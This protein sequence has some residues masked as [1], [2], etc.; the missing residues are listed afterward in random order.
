MKERVLARLPPRWRVLWERYGTIAIGTYFTV[1]FSCIGILFVLFDTGVL[2]PSDLPTHGVGVGDGPDA[3]DG[4]AS[5]YL[6]LLNRLGLESW[7]P[8]T[9]TPRMGNFAIAWLTTKLIEPL[10][11][12]ITIGLT[13]TVARAMGRVPKLDSGETD[14]GAK[15]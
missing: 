5:V 11:A 4:G 10:R 12:L 3:D 13:P 6:W 9:V 7:A 1:Y 15:A 14:D 8:E 2:L